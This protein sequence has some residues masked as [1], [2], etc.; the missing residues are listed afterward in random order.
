MKTIKIKVALGIIL[1]ALCILSACK[2]KITEPVTIGH[3]AYDQYERFGYTVYI[4]EIEGYKPYLV[5]TNEYNGNTLLLR[6]HVLPKL[7]VFN[8]M[9]SYGPINNYYE[10]SEIDSFINNE[11]KETLDETIQKKIVPSTIVIG[12]KYKGYAKQSDTIEIVRDIFLLSVTEIGYKSASSYIE[13]KVL[14]YFKIV[15]NRLAAYESGEKE[16]WWLRT[17]STYSSDAG[18][19]YHSSEMVLGGGGGAV[20]Y[21]NGVRPAFCL[22]NDEPITLRDDIIPGEMVYVL[23]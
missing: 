22:N 18:S 14:K 7:H 11:Y 10:T 17:A 15:E 9:S 5:L 16:N 12:E 8:P 3:L 13:G 4:K 2:Q 20:Y 6:K 21:E 19:A 23:E 1:T